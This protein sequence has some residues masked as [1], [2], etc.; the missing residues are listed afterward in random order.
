MRPRLRPPELAVDGHDTDKSNTSG[1]VVEVVPCGDDGGVP[2]RAAHRQARDRE[3]RSVAV[4]IATRNRAGLLARCLTGVAALDEAPGELIVVDNSAGDEP[5][6]RVAASH[7]ARYVVE[8]RQGVARARNLGARASTMDVVAFLDDDA[9][10]VSGWLSHLLVE[11]GDPS[12]AAVTGRILELNSAA[13][14]GRRPRGADRARVIFGGSHRLVLDGGAADWF[15][16]ANFGG[17]GQGANLAVR[18]SVF[19]DWAGFDTRLGAGT[20]IGSMEEH[21][22]FFS[23]IALGFRI[24]YTPG[25]AVWHPYPAT[26]TELR[27]RHLRQMAGTTSHLALLLAEEPRYRRRAA[28]YALEALAGTARPWRSA[29]PAPDVRRW[30]TT[31]AQLSGIA[32]YLRTRIESADVCNRA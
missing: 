12:V 28:R 15:E 2:D 1:A 22:A 21:H 9:V 3:R 30:Q 7:G 32:L 16:R 11:F 6:Q 10:P 5:T 18:R 31:L 23:L 8:P 4:V 17:V 13:M 26:E 25:A 27:A 14:D 19:E 29:P 24:V 20:K